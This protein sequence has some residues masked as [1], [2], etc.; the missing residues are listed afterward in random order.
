MT[1]LTHKF[2]PATTRQVEYIEDLLPQGGLTDKELNSARAELEDGL[3]KQTAS[4]WIE[5]LLSRRQEFGRKQREREAIEN[6]E[7]SFA[8]I[9]AGHYAVTGNDGTTDF[10]RVDRPEHGKWK[11]FVFVKLQLS[12]E[13][14][15]L[16]IKTQVAISK[17]IEEEGPEK[18]SKKYGRELGRC[19]VC[20]RTLTNPDSIARGI[21][22]VCAGN[23]NWTF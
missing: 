22:P 19:G 3:D 15:R 4:A 7:G 23:R 21:G 12:E 9:P 20:H 10:Y 8:P 1:T 13:Y 5:R 14:V 17:K 18:S 16:P 2:Y 11:G 6:N